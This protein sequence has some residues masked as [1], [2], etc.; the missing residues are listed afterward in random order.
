[1]AARAVPGRPSPSRFSVIVIAVAGF[2]VWPRV[3]ANARN[4]L[5]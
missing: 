4:E 5:Q 2:G 1:M 3:E